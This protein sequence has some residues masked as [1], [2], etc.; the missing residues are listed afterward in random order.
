MSDWP[1]PAAEGSPSDWRSGSRL[2]VAASVRRQG[3]IPHWHRSHLL[4]AQ[5]SNPRRS[6]SNRYLTRHC[7]SFALAVRHGRRQGSAAQPC[8]VAAVVAL[9]RAGY[10]VGLL[11]KPCRLAHGGTSNG[12]WYRAQCG[13]TNGC[14]RSRRP[15]ER[16]DSRRVQAS[17]PARE[18]SAGYLRERR[19]K[20]LTRISRY[21][22][23]LTHSG[24]DTQ[25]FTFEFSQR[26]WVAIRRK[27][28]QH[29]A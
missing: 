29:G 12:V 1:R 2:M 19:R 20:R 6:A 10:F 4:A 27:S 13:N 14:P 11:A 26:T 25:H 17:R 24:D 28:G 22:L 9:A 7:H 15:W 5:H 3:P 18:L 21:G 8:L 16:K 23:T